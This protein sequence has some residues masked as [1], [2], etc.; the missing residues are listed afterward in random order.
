MLRSGT[1]FAHTVTAELP[2]YG[3]NCELIRSLFRY[4]RFLLVPH[5]YIPSLCYPY[6]WHSLPCTILLAA[7][8][9]WPNWCLMRLLEGCY[10]V[11]RM[12]WLFTYIYIYIC[13]IWCG[14]L[15]IISL[16]LSWVIVV[17]N[18]GS[19]NLGTSFLYIY[20]YMYRLSISFTF[21]HWT[22]NCVTLKVSL[23]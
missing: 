19:E 20:M 4:C 17:Q 23:V 5:H 2:W 18:C 6:S 1:K 10:Y 7:T 14:H 9:L 3:P 21:W 22:W 13:R 11:W 12:T 15:W 8:S 16:H